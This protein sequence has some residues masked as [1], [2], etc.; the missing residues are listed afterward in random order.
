ML[1]NEKQSRNTMHG[2]KLKKKL[3]ELGIIVIL[4]SNYVQRRVQKLAFNQYTHDTICVLIN[5]SLQ[6]V[7]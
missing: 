6:R 5:A 1:V 7:A 4:P 3:N 2:E